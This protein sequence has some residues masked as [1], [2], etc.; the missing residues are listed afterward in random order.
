MPALSK[1]DDHR[2]WTVASTRP[3]SAAPA[4]LG[5]TWSLSTVLYDLHNLARLVGSVRSRHGCVVGSRHVS[6]SVPG[7]RWSKQRRTTRIQSVY[8]LRGAQRVKDSVE[9]GKQTGSA[10]GSSVFGA[11]LPG[12]PMP[13]STLRRTP[14]DA[15]RKTQGRNRVAAYKTCR[16]IPAHSHPCVALSS[17]EVRPS[18]PKLKRKMPTAINYA[19]K[20]HSDLG[21]ISC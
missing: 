14:R 19:T 21:N 2:P 17:A 9:I 13:L 10:H 15:P 4:D 1:A 7:I 20:R 18:V 12:P 5:A 3:R 6:G 16:F 11:Q 8:L